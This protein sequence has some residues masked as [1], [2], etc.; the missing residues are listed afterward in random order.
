ML[1]AARGKG[2]HVSFKPALRSQEASTHPVVSIR[3]TTGDLQ[4]LQL[5]VLGKLLEH[6]RE[7]KAGN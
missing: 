5:A 3:G 4:A 1:A 2:E 7:S 6:G